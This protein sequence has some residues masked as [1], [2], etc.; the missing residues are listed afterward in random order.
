MTTIG[1]T[2]PA[3]NTVQTQSR[4][5]ISADFDTFLQMLTTQMKNQDPLN[6]MESTEF[7]TQLATFSGVEQQV[8]TN[9]H[10]SALSAQL[11]L[12]TMAQLSGWIGMEARSDA[13]AEFAGSP[14]ELQLSPE[15]GSDAATLIVSDS[16]GREVQ[17]LPISLPAREVAWAGVDTKG[18]PLPSG[19]YSFALESLAAGER[20]GIAPA[21]HYARVQEARRDADGQ[22]Q[23]VLPGGATVRASEV[24]ALRAAASG[25]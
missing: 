15:P 3:A 19:T 9:D 13:P 17:R 21:T 18:S 6:P 8:R 20:I 14:L 24:T 16:F 4:A 22:V 25:A 23:L 2:T 11:G 1:A 7:A 12:S 10:L 5:M